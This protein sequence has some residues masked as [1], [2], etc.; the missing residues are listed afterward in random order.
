MHNG[1][2]RELLE[3]APV[4]D[5]RTYRLVPGAAPTFDRIFRDEALPLLQGAGIQVVAYGISL[6]DG[7]DYALIRSFPSLRLRNEQLEAFYGSE[8]WRTRFDERVE[9]L[10]ESFRVA[11]IATPSTCADAD[12]S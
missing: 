4:L 10:I 3:A 9:A 7:A 12:A 1:S 5:I 8:L 11:V 6:I 2:S